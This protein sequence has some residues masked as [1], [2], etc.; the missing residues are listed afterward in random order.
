MKVF[1]YIFFFLQLTYDKKKKYLRQTIRIHA[2]FIFL[3]PFKIQHTYLQ[4][5]IDSFLSTVLDY[6]N[7]NYN[8]PI[9]ID[10]TNHYHII[11]FKSTQY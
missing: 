11:L 1:T 8:G 9:K 6:K 4:Y 7:K 3:I 2:L 10:L 5:Q